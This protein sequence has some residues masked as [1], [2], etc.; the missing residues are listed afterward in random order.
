MLRDNFSEFKANDNAAEETDVVSW[1]AS[2]RDWQNVP[3]R[4]GRRGG[5]ERGKEDRGKR[6]RR[7]QGGQRVRGGRAGQSSAQT[8]PE[9]YAKT[10]WI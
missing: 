1:A 5:R 2:W 3:G 7:R 4:K 8:E 9:K 10:S 6:E